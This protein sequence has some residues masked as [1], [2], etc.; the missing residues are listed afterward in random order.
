MYGRYFNETIPEYPARVQNLEYLYRN[1]LT[2]S[3]K[4]AVIE[5]IQVELPTN[6]GGL[7]ML[8]STFSVAVG[9][10]SMSH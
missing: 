1:A 8:M 10:G 2:P 6:L 9:T 4:L 5:R 7:Q 3:E